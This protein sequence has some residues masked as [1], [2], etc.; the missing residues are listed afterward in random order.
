MALATGQITIVDLTD[1]PSIQGYLISNQPKI[2]FLSTTGVYNPSWAASPYLVISAEVYAVGSGTNLVTDSRVTSI[3]WYKNGVEIT[4][5]GGGITLVPAATGNLL[6][7][8]IKIDQNLLTSGAPTMKIS[9]EILYQHTATVSPTPIK[10]EIDYGLSIQGATGA[11]GNTGATGLSAL[12]VILSNEAVTLPASVDGEVSSYTGGAT[13]ISVY[14]GSSLLAHDGV[15]TANSAW[16]VTAVGT[17]ITSG[18]ISDSGSSA[19]V[20]APSAMTADTAKIVFTITGKRANGTAFT[21]TKEQTFAKSKAGINGIDGDDV[22]LVSLTGPQVFKYDEAGAVTPASITLT[23]EK[24]NI[25]TSTYTWAFGLNGATPSTVLNTTN[26]PGVTFAG[27]TVV[28]TAA[29]SG[30]GSA[31]TMT[32]KVTVDGVSDTHTLFKVQDGSIARLLDLTADSNTMTF[33]FNNVA[34]PASQMITF[35]AKP[36]NLTGTVAFIAIPYNAAGTAG[37]AITLTGTGNTRTITQDLWPSTA[38]RLEVEASLSGY[39]DKVTIVKLQETASFSG[40]LTNESITIPASSTGTVIGTLSTLTTGTFKTFYG[41][42]ALAS[43]VSFAKTSNTG[44][45][46]SINATTGVYSLSAI[47]ADTASAIFTATHTASGAVITKTLTVTKSKAGVDGDDAVAISV[48]A[49]NGDVFKSVAGSTPAP[50]TLQCDLYEGGVSV[51]ATAYLWSVQNGAAWD[52]LVTTPLGTTGAATKTLTVPASAV[53]SLENFRCQ[54]TYGGV[55]Y[56]GTATLT[57][58]TDPYLVS[59]IS[60]QGNTFFNGAG[61]AKTLK[62]IVFQGGTEI[63]ID[64]T[65]LTYSWTKYVAG[66][67]QGSAGTGKT[68]TVNASE[69]ATE[70]TYVCDITE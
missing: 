13:Q 67:S 49:P 59:V 70:A 66:V 45:T 29:S 24:Q 4:A 19:N 69:V 55:N 46:A 15:G 64:G 34:K 3:K 25:S 33:D 61:T 10:L 30:W 17:A 52:S 7:T 32:V 11:T 56:Y 68:I 62:A 58:M 22:K 26:F 20:A 54:A 21:L 41:T 44:C 57:D 12:A 36:V 37:T 9:A 8:S 38:V 42:T 60:L 18:V 43:G 27:D 40:Y 48:W 47:S 14:E 65:E 6:N 35:T 28:L 1:L 16:K 5:S 53:P 39:S 63:D 50:L 2:Q 51:N 31:K 23:V